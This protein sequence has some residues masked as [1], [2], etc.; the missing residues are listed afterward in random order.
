M[1]ERIALADEVSA[2]LGKVLDPELDEP[3]TEL[4]FVDRVEA[5]A[6][7]R[8]RI[9]LRLPTYWCAANFAFMMAADARER[10]TELAWVKD[11]EIE[12][13]GH[14]CGDEIGR[15][16]S[17]GRSLA[18][19]FAGEPAGALDGLR[20]IF[21]T[22]AFMRR[23]ERLIRSLLAYGYTPAA[24]VA[25]TIDALEAMPVADADGAR[26]R[27]LYLEAR[28]AIRGGA[29]GDAPALVRSNGRAL[30]AEEFAGYLVELRRVSVNMEFSAELCRGLLRVR[31]SRTASAPAREPEAKLPRQ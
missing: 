3:I 21:R 4:G 16:V 7:G 9:R 1:N 28:R 2:K 20:T 23:Q 11:V 17:E 22:K 15:A 25:M 8:V 14:Y 5:G 30:T 24:L 18:A 6:D 27:A 19:A 31:T 29:A 12:L 13:A 26:R 10:V